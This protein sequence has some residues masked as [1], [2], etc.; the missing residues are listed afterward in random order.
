M[1]AFVCYT[2]RAL[3]IVPDAEDDDERKEG[4]KEDEEGGG[5]GR[6]TGEIGSLLLFTA[7]GPLAY[8]YVLLD[9]LFFS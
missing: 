4:S 6:T 1:S 9:I 3:L 8:S 5:G 2:E 7:D